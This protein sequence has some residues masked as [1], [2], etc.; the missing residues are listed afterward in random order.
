M[1]IFDDFASIAASNDLRLR[2]RERCSALNTSARENGCTSE[3]DHHAC[4]R[5]RIAENQQST[6]R[7]TEVADWF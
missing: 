7:C 3:H 1:N 4:D 5:A 6:V 2:Y